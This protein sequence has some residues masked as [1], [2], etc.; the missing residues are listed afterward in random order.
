MQKQKLSI[1]K[2]QNGV[3]FVSAF[4]QD[5][6]ADLVALYISAMHPNYRM[7]PS[8]VFYSDEMEMTCFEFVKK[9]SLPIICLVT[10]DKGFDYDLNNI[11]LCKIENNDYLQVY[12][13]CGM[14]DEICPENGKKTF[15][16]QMNEK[17]FSTNQRAICSADLFNFEKQNHGNGLLPWLD[18]NFEF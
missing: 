18:D 10:N 7:L 6:L 14:W 1:Y 16:E 15:V 12:V 17:L 11:L 8:S 3:D 13:F 5:Q 9:N 2:N 4:N